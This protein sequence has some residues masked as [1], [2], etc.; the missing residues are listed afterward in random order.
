[1]KVNIDVFLNIEG[2]HTRS[3]GAFNVHPKEYKDNPE[4]AVAIVAYQYI[5]GIIEETGYRETIIDKV[6]YE[7]NKDITDLTKQIRRVPPKDDLP[8]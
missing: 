6:L 5:M 4:L 7:G 8:F 2:Y 3:G 1:M